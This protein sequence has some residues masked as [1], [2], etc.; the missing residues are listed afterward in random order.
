MPK[1][2][3]IPLDM[4]T[5]DN[6]RDIVGVMERRAR[7]MP[8]NTARW[9]R[10]KIVRYINSL[11]RPDPIKPPRV[12]K[13]R[14]KKNLGVGKYCRDV[15]LS[16]VIGKTADGHPIGHSYMEMTKMAQAKFPDSAV[17]ERHLRWYATQAR[18]DGMNIPVY[19]RKSVWI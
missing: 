5:D 15:L 2:M 18:A 6:L 16:A 3:T 8:A 4:M 12:R 10:R 13:K 14:M 11:K 1:R 7:K 9:G 17:D 19:R